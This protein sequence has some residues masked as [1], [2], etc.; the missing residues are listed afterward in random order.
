[1]KRREFIT[2][3]GG[4]AV[5]PVASPLAARAHVPG[6]DKTLMKAQL[7]RLQELGYSDGTNMSIKNHYAV[8][9]HPELLTGRHE[10]LTPWSLPM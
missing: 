1:M 8:K 6:E 9:R 4:A 10:E 3:L 5:V 7:E 2:L